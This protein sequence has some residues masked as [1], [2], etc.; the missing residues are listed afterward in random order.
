MYQ[1]SANGGLLH[2]LAADA[3]LARWLVSGGDER[4]RL[5]ALGR[6]R[7]GV[8]PTPKTGGLSFSSSTASTISA[9]AF[10]AARA[11]LEAILGCASPR[12]AY[13]A[14]AAAIR[15]RLAALCALPP[16]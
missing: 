3:D 7:Y 12:A 16:S 9:G 5:N 10:E 2:T 4:L 15:A 6:N 14:G 11:R 13:H 1:S 8:G